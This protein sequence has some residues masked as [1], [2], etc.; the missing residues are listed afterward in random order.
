MNS[1]LLSVCAWLVVG[2]C[3]WL[4]ATAQTYLTHDEFEQWEDDIRA[5]PDREYLFR[6]INGDIVTGRVLDLSSW[7][8]KT[9]AEEVSAE[10]A[11]GFTVTVDAIT[12]PLKLESVDIAYFGP[13]YDTYRHRHRGYVIPTAQPIGDDAFIGL[14]EIGFLYAGG[15]IGPL[16]ITAGRSFVPGIPARDQFSLVNVKATVAELDNGLVETGKQ[17]YAV[18]F[19]GAW[20]NDKN[21]IGHAFANATFTGV[22]SQTTTTFFAKVAGPELMQVNLGT[23]VGAFNLPLANGAFGVAIS[24]DTRFPEFHDLHAVMELANADITRPANTLLYLGVRTALSSIGMD[25]G[26]ALAPG[27][28]VVPAVAFAWTPF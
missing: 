8:D 27:P 1:V 26:I 23:L 22:R 5:E 15:G 24:I 13:R 20:L 28:T 12:G 25:F 4:P 9:N 7:A 21:F 3:A 17:F 2:M 14:W 16:S 18:G 11:L 10:D 19:N 6:M